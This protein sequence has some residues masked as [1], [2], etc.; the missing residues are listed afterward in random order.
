ME[1][2]ANTIQVKYPTTTYYIISTTQKTYLQ[3]LTNINTT[4]HLVFD[5][6][7]YIVCISMFCYFFVT[8][9]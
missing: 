6:S 9:S 7:E 3:A 4:K 1:F 8:R 5:I 2:T